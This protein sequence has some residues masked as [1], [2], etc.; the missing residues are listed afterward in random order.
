MPEGQFSIADLDFTFEGTL[1]ELAQC[2]KIVREC[3]EGMYLVAK[4]ADVDMEEIKLIF[5]EI[6]GDR[7]TFTMLRLRAYG[8]RCNYTLD[9]SKGGD[10]PLGIYCD[11]TKD[12]EVYNRETEES[13][14]IS[15]PEE[16]RHNSG[17]QRSRPENARPSQSTGAKTKPSR[18]RGDGRPASQQSEQGEEEPSQKDK[19]AALT[20][21]KDKVKKNASDE[22]SKAADVNVDGES[23][24]EKIVQF[25]GYCNRGKEYMRRVLSVVGA[26]SHKVIPLKKIGRALEMIASEDVLVRAE[27]KSGKR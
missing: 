25:A 6:E 16:S 13:W 18:G 12:I 14:S 22:D 27:K 17:E 1:D 15:D 8:E 21:L 20:V 7:G 2:Q 4:A 11:R 3:R 5:D 9:L 26:K 19:N 10:S 23:L 24:P